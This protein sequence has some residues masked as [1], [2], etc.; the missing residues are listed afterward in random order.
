MAGNA[1]PATYEVG[2]RQFVVVHATGGL[3]D[4]VTPLQ[5]E[6]CTG[7]GFRFD[8]YSADGLRW[9][10]DEAMKFHALPA[11]RRAAQIARIMR[12]SPVEFSHAARHRARTSSRTGTT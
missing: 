6:R 4:T 7:N 11:D 1:T 10:I 3:H 8:I 9:A 2:G 12:E 5:V